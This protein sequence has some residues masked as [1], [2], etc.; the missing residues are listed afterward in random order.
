MLLLNEFEA[1][2]VVILFLK[3]HYEKT[4]PDDSGILADD[5]SK[6][7]TSTNK[8]S[9]VQ[10]YWIESLEYIKCSVINTQN[11]PIFTEE[12][13]FEAMYLFLEKY[14]AR[15]NSDDIGS[16]LGDLMHGIYGAMAD[17]A[18]WYIWQEC[19]GKVKKQ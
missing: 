12:E 7:N 16:L 6:F 10:E 15:T 4:K 17:P 18:A 11:H 13:A 9:L 8:Y 3:Q 19:L 1:L 5:L 14:Y 2:Q